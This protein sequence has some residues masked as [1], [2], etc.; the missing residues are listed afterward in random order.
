MK[1]L[2]DP[3]S[4]ESFGGA[5]GGPVGGELI[6]EIIAAL[7]KRMTVHELAVLPHYDA[8]QAEIWTYLAEALA[9]RIPAEQ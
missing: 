6:H 1:L 3:P 7:A 9:E 4:G 8:M 5:C 2:A